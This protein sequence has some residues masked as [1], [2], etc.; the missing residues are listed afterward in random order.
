MFEEKEG[1]LP[2]AIKKS[3]LNSLKNFRQP[4]HE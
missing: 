1:Q 3:P 4:R 2:E